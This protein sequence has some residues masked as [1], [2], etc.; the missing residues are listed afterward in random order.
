VN[1]GKSMN[2]L[3]MTVLFTVPFNFLNGMQGEESKEKQLLRFCTQ[4]NLAKVQYLLQGGADCNYRDKKGNTPLMRALKS[5]HQPV[6]FQLLQRKDI[7]AQYG[8]KK[9][10]TALDYAQKWDNGVEGKQT[11]VEFVQE[12]QK[13]E[14]IKKELAQKIEKLEKAKHSIQDVLQDLFFTKCA[15]GNEEYIKQILETYKQSFA[16]TDTND[17]GE[18]PLMVAQ[19]NGHTVLAHFLLE[20]MNE[21]K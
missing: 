13:R 11:V 18:T 3:F 9:G 17:E 20:Q 8:N 5:A 7:N 16:L 12:L 10:K 1:K 4:G 21:K 15:Q 14:T 6:V 19:K 2:K